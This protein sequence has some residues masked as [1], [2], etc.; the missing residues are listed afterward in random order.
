MMEQWEKNILQCAAH[1]RV[2]AVYDPPAENG[3][4]FV[5]RAAFRAFLFAAVS[6]L[7]NSVLTCRDF[8]G[9]N[10]VYWA[11]FLAACLL[12]VRFCLD[13]T[14]LQGGILCGFC[15]RHAACGL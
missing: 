6:Y 14:W 1:C 12:L 13:M 9:W 4:R 15:L 10:L 3:E 7:A 11:A 8:S 5:P 2:R